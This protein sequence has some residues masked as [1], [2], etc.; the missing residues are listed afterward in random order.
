MSHP[1][2]EV[3]K[4]ELANIVE[5]PILLDRTPVLKTALPMAWRILFTFVIQVLGTKVDIGEITYGDLDEKFRS[6]TTILSNSNFSKDPSKVTPIELTAFMIAINNHETLVSPLLFSV[7]TKK[8]KSQTMTPTLPKSQGP[9]ASGALSKKRNKPKTTQLP[10]KGSHSSLDEETRKSQTLSEGTT[11]DP[12]DLG[13]NIQLANK[14]LPSTISDE[15]TSKTKSLPEGLRED[16]DL[17]RLKPLVDMESQNPPVTNL[18]ATDAKY[19]TSP[20]VE[21]DTHTLILSTATDVQA[22]LLSDDELIK[23][24][25]DDVFEAEDEI[26]EDI[27]QAAEEE[28]QSPK[29]SRESTKIPTKETQSQEHQSPS[30]NQDQPETS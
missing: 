23:E 24:S 13:G 9:E 12:K 15:G 2:P 29:P 10:D 22:L 4:A 11:T 5:N 26:D 8:A 20:E 7:K 25:E 1:S 30:L 14:G 16:K 3:V 17:E 19:Q 6:P 21:L 27:Q 18:L 28:V